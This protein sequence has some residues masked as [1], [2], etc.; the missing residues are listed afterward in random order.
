MKLDNDKL[1]PC[2]VCGHHV[3]KATA[4]KCPNCGKELMS[5]KKKAEAV[6]KAIGG[7]ITIVLLW[8]LG[9]LG[10]GLPVRFIVP[11]RFGLFRKSVA[12]APPVRG[13][14]LSSSGFDRPCQTKPFPGI[15]FVASP[16]RHFW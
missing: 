10:P 16:R 7:I 9:V 2:P 15:E 8:K 14:I 1:V 12:A 4:D 5:D 11:D 3:S 13:E 6:G